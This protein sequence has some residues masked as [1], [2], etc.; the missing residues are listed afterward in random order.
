MS[1]NMPLRG[2]LWRPGTCGDVHSPTGIMIHESPQPGPGR[3]AAH[4]HPIDSGLPVKGHILPLFFPGPVYFSEVACDS[5]RP[6]FERS[7]RLGP[8]SIYIERRY[9]A[10]KSAASANL[11][12]VR[13]LEYYVVRPSTNISSSKLPWSNSFNNR[14]REFKSGNSASTDANELPIQ[15]SQQAG[16]LSE[17]KRNGYWAATTGE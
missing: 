4:W 12:I 7:A 2:S 15:A 5:P 6:G 17:T 16:V 10:V 9:G 3:A 14:T 1:F 8:L 11:R 13:C